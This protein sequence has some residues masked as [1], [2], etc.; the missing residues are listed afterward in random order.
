MPMPSLYH[1]RLIPRQHRRVPVAASYFGAP[2]V[3]D[4]G[5]E[6]LQPALADVATQ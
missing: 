2:T 4:A 3:G 5:A 6:Y 1:F